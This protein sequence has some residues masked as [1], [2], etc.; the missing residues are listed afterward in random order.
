MIIN[1]ARPFLSSSDIDKGA[2]W[3]TEIA[4]KLEKAKAG[5]I[6]LTQ[7]NMRSEWILFE[8]GAL[9]K[10]LADTYVC[11]LLIGL[12]PTDVKGPLSQF[13]AT[14]AS[15]S[16]M[17]QLVK[18]LN[19]RLGESAV[20]ASQLEKAFAL[21]WPE[22]NGQLKKLPDEDG[23]SVPGR[24]Q[25]DMLEELL[26]LVRNLNRAT[27]ALPIFIPGD[28]KIAEDPIGTSLSESTKREVYKLTR[29]LF[30]DK[31]YSVRFSKGVLRG[32]QISLY[33]GVD[34]ATPTTSIVVPE[35]SSVDE[36]MQQIKA[37]LPPEYLET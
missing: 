5:I 20:P 32:T 17:L 22:L 15:Q 13:Q 27:P 33:L 34:P 8:A 4:G 23:I 12:K 29:D 19:S 6:C 37:A 18:T 28:P 21:M 16:D 31:F 10:T 9:S 30:E 7:N 2:R 3:S 11:T 24:T 1:A 26:G 36:I 35:N 25:E 14:T